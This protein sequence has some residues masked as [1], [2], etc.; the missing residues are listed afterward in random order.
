ME[1]NYLNWRKTFGIKPAD[2]I[3]EFIVT[4]H[5]VGYYF[6]VIIYFQENK[7]RRNKT[8]EPAFKLVTKHL[9]DPTEEGILTQFTDWLAINL[10]EKKYKIVEKEEIIFDTQ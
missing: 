8:I 10:K 4:S 3:V 9:G 6:G 7:T 5:K 1:Q 2:E